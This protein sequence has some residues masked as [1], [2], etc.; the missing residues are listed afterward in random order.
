MQ[1]GDIKMN[2]YVKLWPYFR[3]YW[4]R[5]LLVFLSV[6]LFATSNVYLMA[7]VKE[8][9]SDIERGNI[10]L[11]IY[12]I[13]TGVLLVIIR[14]MAMY[15]QNYN[16]AWVGHRLVYKL[17]MEIYEHLQKMSLD[18]YSKWKVGELI[19]RSTN[20]LQVVQSAFIANIVELLPETVTFIGVLIYLAI[21]NWQLLAMTF[22]TIP[23][24]VFLINTFGK[25]MKRISRYN[26]RKM[27][28]I[29]SILQETLNGINIIRAFATEDKEIARYRKENERSF[30]I[31]T[32]ADRLYNIQSPILFV[33]QSTMILLIFMVGGIQMIQGDL[34]VGNFLAFVTGLGLLV[35]PVTI[36]GKVHS[37]QQKANAALTRVFEL[38]DVEPTVKEKDTAVDVG[39]IEGNVIFDNVNFSYSN[40][41]DYVLRDINV[42][43]KKGELIALVGSSGSGKTTMVNLIPRF[44]NVNEGS[45]MID[46]QDVQELRLK[47]YRSQVGIVA[48]ETILFSGSIRDNIAYAKEEASMDEI[49]QAAKSANAH[50]FIKM[51][52]SGYNTMV[53]EKGVRLSGGQRQRIAIAR[54]ILNN[55]RILILDEATSALDTESERLVQAALEKLMAGRTTFAIAHRLSTIQNADRILVLDKGRIVE[56]G[57]HEYLLENS[58]IYKNLY[59]MQFKNKRIN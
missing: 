42:N 44:Y 59:E 22:I 40:K 33:L 39:H 19:S 23:V 10:G 24:F 49:V 8:L 16:M 52:P 3:K 43:V 53:G 50:E 34:T 32:R 27:A 45:I 46:G 13:F 18:F 12:R 7:L 51:F 25:T 28:D 47:S 30:W 17:R 38:L 15:G 29:S 57:N 37:R 56:E 31:N 20:D 26:Q 55:P 11:F 48:Q 21:L 14:S 4:G 1:L 9:S 54:A 35:N 36:F 2:I 6:F 58:L 5:L 41:D